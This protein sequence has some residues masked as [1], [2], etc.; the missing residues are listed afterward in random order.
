MKYSDLFEKSE[1][2]QRL[3]E[4]RGKGTVNV[5]H[6]DSTGSV[7]KS[8]VD[9]VEHTPRAG[10]ASSTPDQA[11]RNEVEAMPLAAIRSELAKLGVST[12]GA[13]EKRVRVCPQPTAGFRVSHPVFSR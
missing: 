3:I 10:Q 7:R 2:V 1:F 11:I 13:F 12:Q 8:T 4:A 9:S 6:A 5:E